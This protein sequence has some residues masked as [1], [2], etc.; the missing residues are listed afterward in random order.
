MPNWGQGS[1]YSMTREGRKYLLI[2][3]GKVGGTPSEYWYQFNVWKDITELKVPGV[4]PFIEK[5]DKEG[6]SLAIADPI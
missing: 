2:K 4:L 1:F 5:M 6:E 3:V